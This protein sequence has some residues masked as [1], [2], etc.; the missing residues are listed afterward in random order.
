MMLFKWGWF[1]EPLIRGDYPEEM[2][3]H[4]GNTLPAFTDEEKAL[5]K[6]SADFIGVNT[7]TS[8][9]ISPGE[10]DGMVRLTHAAAVPQLAAAQRCTPVASPCVLWL[11]AALCAAERRADTICHCWCAACS[12]GLRPPQTRQAIPWACLRMCPGCMSLLWH[13]G[14]S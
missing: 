4:F 10:A 2:K 9:F 13:C 5:L 14:A 7:Y 8:R 1:T 12:P 11:A 3:A 6:G